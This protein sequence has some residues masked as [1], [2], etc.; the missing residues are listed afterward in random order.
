MSFDSDAL[1]EHSGALCGPVG[2][3]DRTLSRPYRGAKWSEK[4]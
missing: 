1:R 2:V 4:E 3:I